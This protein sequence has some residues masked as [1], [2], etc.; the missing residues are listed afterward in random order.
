MA[1]RNIGRQ[2]LLEHAVQ[3]SE[4]GNPLAPQWCLSEATLTTVE[5]AVNSAEQ[6]D[7]ESVMLQMPNRVGTQEVRLFLAY[8][9]GSQDD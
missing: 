8:R 1:I 5:A 7:L 2:T 9:A 4:Q 6:N 3:A